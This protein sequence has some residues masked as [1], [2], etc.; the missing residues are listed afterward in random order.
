MVSLFCYLDY[1]LKII[2][3]WNDFFLP[4]HQMNLTD[5]TIVVANNKRIILYKYGMDTAVKNQEYYLK[6]YVN[7][8]PND[9]IRYIKMD[10][11]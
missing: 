11:H 7:K 2:L 3:Y 4:I 8:E 10:C 5:D 6:M 9:R 1:R